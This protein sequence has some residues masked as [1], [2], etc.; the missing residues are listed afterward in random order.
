MILRQA[1]INRVMRKTIDA[2]GVTASD[3]WT[4]ATG[5]R[6]E[7]HDIF[8]SCSSATTVTLFFDTDDVTNRVFKGY[9]G[10]NQGVII[11]VTGTI[12]SSINSVLKI[13]NVNPTISVTV[14]GLEH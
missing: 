11:S 7:I 4:P 8:I 1:N 3:V 6:I 5:K 13:T 2:A 9:F 14:V 12:F 10:A